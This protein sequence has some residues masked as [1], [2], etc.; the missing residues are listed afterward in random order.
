MQQIKIPKLNYVEHTASTFV[1][2]KLYLYAYNSVHKACEVPERTGCA[3]E[4]QSASL[5]FIL[6]VAT[7]SS[8]FTVSGLTL[9]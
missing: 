9:K 7:G 2:A 3:V 8:V 1:I 6:K 4:I 5:A